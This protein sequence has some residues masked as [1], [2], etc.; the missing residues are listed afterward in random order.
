MTLALHSGNFDDEIITGLQEQGITS[1]GQL[2]FAVTA[3]G[4]S[5]SDEQ[6]NAFMTQAVPGRVLTLGEMANFT[7]LVF[8]SQT[9]LIAHL[10]ANSDPAADPTTRISLFK[11]RR[12]RLRPSKIFAGYFLNFIKIFGVIFF[13]RV[14]FKF[15]FYF[16][17]NFKIIFLQKIKIIFFINFKI[18]FFINFKI[19][20]LQKN[21]NN[22]SA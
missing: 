3:P 11:F 1:L 13:R 15:I 12:D 8:E 22:F 9:A 4:A 14:N 16:F 18:I 19:I 6:I 17:T 7:R 10:K 2:A 20:F 21:K 5:P